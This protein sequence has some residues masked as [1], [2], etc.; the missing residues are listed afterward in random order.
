M[1]AE[2]AGPDVVEGHGGDD[3]D[4]R[5]DPGRVEEVGEEDVVERLEEVFPGRER[6]GRGASSERPAASRRG[7]SAVA[8][9]G[10][11]GATPRHG[12]D[13][14]RSTE[15]AT[16]ARY[17]RP[18]FV[19]A[20]GAQG[21]GGGAREVPGAPYEVQPGACPLSVA[22]R[23]G[24]AGLAGDLLA[25]GVEVYAT[26][27]TREHLAAD[28]LDVLP[29]A[30]LTNVP[31]LVGGMVKTFHPAVTRGSWRGA[32][33]R[34]SSPSLPSMGSASSTSWSSTSH[35]RSPG[36][37]APRAPRRGDRD[38]RRRR[39]G[40]PLCRGPQPRRRGRRAQPGSLRAGGGRDPRPGLRLGGAAPAPRGRG[41]RHRCRLPR[42][43]RRVP[44]PGHRDHVPA[45]PERRPAEGRRPRPR[46]EP[47]P[48]S[49]LLP[50]DHPP[51]RHPGRRHPPAG[52]GAL[53]QRPPRPRRRVA[54]RGRLRGPDGG[55]RASHRPSRDRLRPR[56]RGGPPA[57]PR[58]GPGR[59]LRQHRRREP[60]GRRGDRPGDRRGDVRGAHRP[61]FAET[62][63]RVLA[64]RPELEVLQVPRTRPTACGTTG[65]PPS[66][67]SGSA[68]GSS[69]RLWT[70]RPSIA[71]SCAS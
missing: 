43:G 23:Q 20:A 32:I 46:R 16:V 34:S 3:P 70:G 49:C 30:A 6:H 4:D 56:P 41:L 61:G 5:E 12:H 60:A 62:A 17:T 9:R 22:N 51:R 27:G 66:T 48:A 15:Y 28:G 13:R 26:D 38:D 39:H 71:A 69:S 31:S 7:R 40:P 33:G 59:R 44:Q 21:G 45:P 50:R 67:S 29:V 1:A 47:P 55:R 63:L 65:S 37:R 57:G 24:L 64:A 14:G 8:R 36:Q 2:L 19:N 42:G 11:G 18:R 68:V 54:D 58:D 35:L 25:L 53:V 10:T 52:P